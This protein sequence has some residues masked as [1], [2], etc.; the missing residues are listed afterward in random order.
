MMFKDS[1]NV[2]K[3]LKSSNDEH[4][5]RQ[6]P[7]TQK[8]I[9]KRLKCPHNGHQ[10]GI[11]DDIKDSTRCY[12]KALKSDTKEVVTRHIQRDNEVLKKRILQYSSSVA[13][14]EH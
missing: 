4:Q 2:V 13:K 14:I 6:H 8:M 10:K 3:Y 7:S 11:I 5:R 1:K 9:V 12:W